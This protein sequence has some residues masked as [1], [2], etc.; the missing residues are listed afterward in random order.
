MITFT[1]VVS[2][3]AVSCFPLTSPSVLHSLSWLFLHSFILIWIILFRANSC[4]LFSS[5]F[6]D[7]K[8]GALLSEG[9]ESWK[10][11]DSRTL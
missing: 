10:D 4:K 3:T 1:C 9:P 8:E 5:V 2:V 11:S 7:K 6:S